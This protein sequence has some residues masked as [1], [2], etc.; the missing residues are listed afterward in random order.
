[1]EEIKSWTEFTEAEKEARRFTALNHNWNG[2]IGVIDEET[3]IINLKE[4]VVEKKEE[5]YVEDFLIIDYND[6]GKEISRKVNIDKVADYLIEKFD[7][8]TIFGVKE[9]S[10]YV[11]S[12]GI[13]ERQGRGILIG[14][15]ERILGS[16]AKN[17]GVKEIFDKIKRKTESNREEFD[18]VPENM[19]ATNNHI[20][21]VSPHDKKY[22]FKKKFNINYNP[23]LDCP[24][25]KK[26]ISKTFYPCDIPQIQEYGG[27]LLIKKYAFKKAVILQGPQNTGK[28]V[29]LNLISSF[30]GKKNV[31]GLSL[32]K[33][34]QGKTFDLLV[35]KDAFVNIHDDLSG[36]DLNDTG[37]FK[38][39]VGDGEICGEEKF[40]DYIRFKNSAKH[41]FACN[42]IPSVKEID[43]D[44]Y[45]G[46]WLI[47]VLD[48]VILKKN[49]DINLINKLT[50][51]EE[52]SGLLNWFIEGYIRL[53]KNNGFSNEKTC[54]ETR[55]LMIHNSNPIAKF[56]SERLI[57]EP[58][59]KIT[60]EEMY[61]AYC[62]FCT[63]QV[64][65]IS[66]DSKT[67]IG[68]SL[69]RFAPFVQ[70]AKSGNERYW[71][72][73]KIRDTWDTFSISLEDDLGKNS[74][75]NI[76]DMC[77][78]KVSQLPQNNSFLTDKE[79]EELKE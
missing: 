57:Y 42:K 60:K 4:K 22:N 17:N 47:W 7:I 15:I 21:D 33:I 9:E 35:L 5:I 14:E 58:G 44:A 30:C 16:Y 49:R 37:G 79:F 67:K 18:I 68:N 26:F 53:V 8:K 78:S 66:P 10:L 50:T 6:K 40:G 20:I 61:M 39:A 46:R 52:L 12:S 71:L 54:E 55:E 45:Y 75:E 34:S 65:I 27:M 72:N 23:N 11:Y 32:Q 29:F 70:D 62:E 73:A 24:K 19:I 31:A 56:A 1:M 43:D 13:W 77:F 69:T 28:T 51:E 63:K 59:S 74:N 25:I 64:P 36:N 76:F 2:K 38:K 3:G 41:L 48:K